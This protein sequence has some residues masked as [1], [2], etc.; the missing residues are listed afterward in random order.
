MLIAIRK[1]SRAVE[2]RS[3]HAF[4]ADVLASIAITAVL[5]VGSC[6]RCIAADPPEDEDPAYTRVITERA[7]KIVRQLGVDDPARAIRVRD[8]I[9]NQYRGLSRI[10]DARDADI[11]SAKRQAGA[12]R[13]TIDAEIERIRNDANTKMFNLHRRFVARL[14]AELAPEQVGMVKDGMT[15]GVVQVTYNHYLELLPNLTEE[16]QAEILANLLEAREYAM[17]AGSSGEKHGWF[18][19]YK[20]RIN[21]YLSAA[22]YNMKQAENDWAERQRAASG[23]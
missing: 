15:Y 17:D 4:L 2:V 11:A 8:V 3:S 16:Q 19:K 9:A 13:A 21:N 5:T 18:R 7:D 14:A 23:N 6:T 20:G 12:A 22:G 10:H 1:P